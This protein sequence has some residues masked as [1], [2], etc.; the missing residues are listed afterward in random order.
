MARAI[1][2]IAFGPLDLA[3]LVGFTLSTNRASVRVMEKVGFAF[4]R[5]IVHANLPH[6]LYRRTRSGGDV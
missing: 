4:E 6:M 3:E 1:L 2:S 5:A